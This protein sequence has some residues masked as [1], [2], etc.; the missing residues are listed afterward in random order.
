MARLDELERRGTAN[1]CPAW[2]GWIASSIAEIEPHVRAL[3]G[4]HSPETG[5]VDYG[6]VAAAYADD[7][8]DGRRTIT[9]S[10]GVTGVRVAPGWLRLTHTSGETRARHALFCAGGWSDRLATMAGGGADPRIV[11]F[12]GAYM[13]LRPERR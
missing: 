2:R 10:C 1:G 11:P 12:R 3:D 13:R 5:I 6:R 8:G 7:R 9:T 4:L